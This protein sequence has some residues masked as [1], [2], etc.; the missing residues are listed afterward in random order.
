M[1][2]KRIK[3][4][5][6]ALVLMITISSCTVV[7]PGYKAMKWQPW[8]Q[9]LKTDKIYDNGAIWHWPWVGVVDYNTQWQTFTEKVSVLT[10]DELH[11]D[12]VVSVTL[13]PIIDELPQLELKVGQQYYKTVVR[14]EFISIT[15]NIFSKYPY[16]DVS[17][18]S[19]EIEATIFQL[20]KDKVKDKHLV[21]DNVTV[22]H[23]IYP[24]IVS[25][26]VNNKLAVEQDIEQKDYEIEIAKKTAEI[27]RILARGQRDAQ[28]IID[29][30]IT[31]KYL[32]YKALEVQDKLSTSAN[33]KFFFVPLG[34]DGLP[35]IVDA[36]SGK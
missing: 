10:E 27:Q 35:I 6:L 22:N 3:Y 20:L 19:V 21:F 14:P 29:S 9:G 25:A 28:T 16:G 17:P 7:K 12:L 15:R 18:K 13:K 32:Q 23:I 26:A 8:G 34:K 5:V 31:Q 33:A 30:S 36:G 2:N 4:G 24:D 11:I 1:K